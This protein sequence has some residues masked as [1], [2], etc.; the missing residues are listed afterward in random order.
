MGEAGRA[1]VREE[2][3]LERMVRSYENLYDELTADRKA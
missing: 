2:F 3:S 1:R